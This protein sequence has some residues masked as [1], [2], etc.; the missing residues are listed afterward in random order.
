MRGL[1]NANLEGLEEQVINAG[2]ASMTVQRPPEYRIERDLDRGMV[3]PYSLS[4]A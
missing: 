1:V 4:K 3:A 2:N